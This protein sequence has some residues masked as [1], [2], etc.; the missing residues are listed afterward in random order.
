MTYSTVQTVNGAYLETT[1]SC[2]SDIHHDTNEAL[3]YQNHNIFFPVTNG[4][5]H[6][7]CG[8]SGNY[9][10]DYNHTLKISP[11]SAVVK[12]EKRNVLLN[13]RKICIEGADLDLLECGFICGEDLH[14][15]DIDRACGLLL[16]FDTKS[17]ITFKDKFLQNL[18]YLK[19]KGISGFENIR[20]PNLKIL[21]IDVHRERCLIKD[22]ITSNLET[23]IF[24]LESETLPIM[25]NF[26]LHSLKN[27][28]MNFKSPS[29][30]P[31]ESTSLSINEILHPFPSSNLKIT[32]NSSLPTSKPNFK[33]LQYSESSQPIKYI[34]FNTFLPNL[35]KLTI[36]NKGLYKGWL[37]LSLE[38]Y[39]NL[40]TLKC[41]SSIRFAFVGNCPQLHEVYSM[42]F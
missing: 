35:D 28:V 8:R 6:D 4:P 30:R 34:E 10:I 32:E 12:S 5:F 3:Q 1:N 27:L 41:D 16:E 14:V 2:N 42:E 7:G 36:T 31:C 26:Q 37:S 20:C 24:N 17:I 38:N 22:I 15:L 18:K 25:D 33:L 19:I 23:L 11:C 13:D 29:I 40:K 39:H 21:E 9:M